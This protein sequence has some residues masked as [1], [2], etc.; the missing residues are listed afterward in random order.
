MTKLSTMKR[1]VVGAPLWVCFRALLAGA[2]AAITGLPSAAPA[3]DLPPLTEF[4]DPNVSR[5]A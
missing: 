2:T 5:H 3:F 4:D 1:D